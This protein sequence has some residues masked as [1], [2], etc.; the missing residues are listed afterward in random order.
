MRQTGFQ[1]AKPYGGKRVKVCQRTNDLHSARW[2]RSDTRVR[3]ASELKLKLELSHLLK[4]KATEGR[5]TTVLVLSYLRSLYKD[6]PKVGCRVV[7]SYLRISPRLVSPSPPRFAYHRQRPVRVSG[8][9][10]Q[11]Q[12]DHSRLTPF[13]STSRVQTSSAARPSVQDV[14]PPLHLHLH[15]HLPPKYD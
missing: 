8:S 5:S 6:T 7:S 13:P 15:L 2:S 1:T 3:V 9:Q 4:A 14:P 11:S 10:T 12:L